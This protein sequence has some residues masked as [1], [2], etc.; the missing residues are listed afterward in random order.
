[1]M[2]HIRSRADVTHSAKSRVV[3]K[4]RVIH[5]VRVATLSPQKT[6][7][8]LV[9]GQVTIPCTIGKSGLA[10][11]KREGDGKTPRGNFTLTA[12]YYRKDR[13]RRFQ[14][15]QSLLEI[16]PEMGWCDDPGSFRYNRPLL[17][18]AS[19]RHERLW[20]DDEL[21][22]ALFVLSYNI[23]P[24]VLGRGSA[25]FFH[26]CRNNLAPTEGCVAVRL[27]DMLRIAPLLARNVRFTIV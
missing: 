15:R 18:P 23:R 13:L 20:R 3:T 12:G 14:C 2:R 24:R 7:G 4:S 21:Y 11:H 6:V 26:V 9:V 10:F 27:P 8:R 25:I 5:C 16:Y 17:L 22:D 1:M 19:S